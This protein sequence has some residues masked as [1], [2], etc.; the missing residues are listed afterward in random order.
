MIFLIYKDEFI[1]TYAAIVFTNTVTLSL[2][3]IT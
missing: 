1:A 2:K 3:E